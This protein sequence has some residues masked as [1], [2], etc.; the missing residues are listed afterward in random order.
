[1]PGLSMIFINCGLFFDEDPGCEYSLKFDRI[2][3]R[4][5]DGVL[6]AI[7]LFYYMEGN[8]LDESSDWT[9]EFSADGMKTLS[10]T[11]PVR[12]VKCWGSPSVSERTGKP[13]MTCHRERYF[14]E[15]DYWNR[16]SGM[17]DSDGNEITDPYFFDN[18]E[19]TL[20]I[21]NKHGDILVEESYT[22]DY[23]VEGLCKTGTLSDAPALT[24]WNFNEDNNTCDMTITFYKE[25]SDAVYS[26]FLHVSDSKN[27][28]PDGQLQVNDVEGEDIT[29]DINDGKYTWRS[30]M[31]GTVHFQVSI[32]ATKGDCMPTEKIYS[33]TQTRSDITGVNRDPL[34]EIESFKDKWGKVIEFEKGM[35]VA[36][37]I[38]GPFSIDVYTM[39]LPR[40]INK[41]LY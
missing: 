40:P 17:K 12:T 37:K 23:D 5:S 8:A 15:D 30:T 4:E 29:T 3:I 33:E 24:V 28:N 11:V 25:I 21:K 16:W 13:N 39:L 10:T 38:D 14:D 7:Q 20:T 22:F 26:V 36:P 2:A 27:N 9:V 18:R 1:M 35:D 41:A 19:I 32:F 31:T 34:I 6:W